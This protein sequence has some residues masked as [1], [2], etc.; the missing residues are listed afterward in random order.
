[1]RRNLVFGS[2]ALAA[3]VLVSARSLHGAR[4]SAR[5][6]SQL[7]ETGRQLRR[8]QAS[9]D[10]LLVELVNAQEGEA[11]KI[12][13][14]LHDDVVQQLTA[15]AFRLELESQR[16]DLPRLTEIARDASSITASIRRLLVGLHP[17]I[18]DSQ[19]LGPAVDVVADG[20]RESGVDVRVS[21][22]PHRLPRELETLIYRLVQE[23]LAN[24]QRHSDARYA[25]VEL[26]IAD[27]VLRG[28]ITD[29][30][31]GTTLDDASADGLGLHVARERVELGGG[32]FLV[33]PRPG[34][35]TDVVFELPL[36]QSAPKEA[37][38]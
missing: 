31:S 15:L 19:G 13:D 20:L 30:G 36:P 23:A 21:A 7:E 8:A 12:A 10:R 26:R 14:L 33:Q 18:L 16:H 6:A 9:R 27:G 35:G 38:S 4:A 32:R 29:N 24:V 34:H 5:H 22:F 2:L 1:M 17:A 37:V 25:E 11:R 3:G 28:R